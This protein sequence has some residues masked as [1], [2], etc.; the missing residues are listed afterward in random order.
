MSTPVVTVASGGLPVVE[1]AAGQLGLPV[2]EATNGFGIAVTKVV[3]KP[4]LPVVFDT[5]GGGG[6]SD[7]SFANVEL[8]LG[9]NGADAATTTTDEGPDARAVTFLNGAQID[10]A[11]FKFGSSSL[12][13]DGVDDIVTVPDSTDWDFAGQF[14]IECW[15]RVPTVS[16]GTRTLVAKRGAASTNISW[17]MTATLGATSGIGLEFSTDGISAVHNVSAAAVGLLAANTWYHLAVDRDASNKIRVYLD[18]VMRASKVA[19][20]GTA[21]NG[22]N[23]LSIGGRA[24]AGQPWPG[25]ID[26]VRIKSTAQYASDGGFTPPAAAFPRS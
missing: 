24:N 11:Q 25:W 12:L 19:A 22:T 7:P 16:G 1:L 5:G 4:G 10:T 3:G 15:F 20:S 8:L 21:F 6:A 2:T 9:F 17:D 23:A 18:G 14:T 26:E 13:L